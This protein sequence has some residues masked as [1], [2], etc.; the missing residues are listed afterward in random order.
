MT[1][2][3]TLEDIRTLVSLLP[4]AVQTFD[5]DALSDAARAVARSVHFEFG[6]IAPLVE[7]QEFANDLLANGMFRL[8]FDTVFLTGNAI[9]KTGIVATQEVADGKL[10]RLSWYIVA[11]AI[12]GGEAEVGVP[13]MSGELVGDDLAHGRVNWRSLTTQPHGSR[14]T[15]RTWSEDDYASGADKALLWILTTTVLLMSKDVDVAVERPSGKMN[16]ERERKGKLPVAERRVVK[17]KMEKRA[18]Y[19]TSV[20]DFR[21]G[22]SSPRMHWR[23]GHMRTIRP[24]VVVPVAP[25]IVNASPDSRPAPKSYEVLR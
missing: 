13:L 14:K 10:N 6:N 15:G 22:K 21:S 7:H 23:R 2:H 16:R 18:A 3:G 17:I 9:P 25:S 5:T 1:P 24:G 12:I 11:P 19:A 20:D 4:K 8:P